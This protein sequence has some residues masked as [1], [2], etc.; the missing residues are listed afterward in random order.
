MKEEKLL[1]EN[2]EKTKKKSMTINRSSSE[3]KMK[4]VNQKKDLKNRTKSNYK[5]INKQ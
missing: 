2:I 4:V 5:V 3:G 1:L